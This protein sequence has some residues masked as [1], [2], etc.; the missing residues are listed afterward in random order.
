MPAG[1]SNAALPR[2]HRRGGDKRLI[3]RLFEQLA[4]N[5][6]RTGDYVERD[7]AGRP[8]QVVIAGRYAV[9]YWANHADKKVK[10]IDLKMAGS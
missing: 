4:D 2:L 5:P 7:D 6:F 9:C 1:R 8:I 3:T 10:V